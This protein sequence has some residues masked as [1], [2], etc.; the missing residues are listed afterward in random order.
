MANAKREIVVIRNADKD[1]GWME[2]W[3]MPRNR[4][5][6]AIPHPFRLLATASVG[7]G[8]TN[9]AKNILLAHQ[10]MPRR[11]QFKKLI[12]I[13]CDPDS[14][15]WNDCEPTETMQEI[16]PASH[17]NGKEKTLV[18]LDDYEFA[19]TNKEQQK[20]L[21]TLF[22]HVSTHKNVSLMCLYQSFYRCPKIIRTCCD[23]F[24][25]WKP[26][27]KREMR[28]VAKSI[29]CDCEDVEYIFNKICDGPYDSLMID[30]SVGTPA[31]MR[32][33]I[34]EPIRKS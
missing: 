6:A 30:C 2:N 23:S 21:T 4:S 34:H 14:K 10:A 13:N 25:V 24:M 12:V 28:S 8:K 32:K 27:S 16:P 29:G 33:N 7:R 1:G 5:L 3:K 19:S 22:R 9:S 17:F 31:R 26:N 15:E 20:R 18:V 11:Y